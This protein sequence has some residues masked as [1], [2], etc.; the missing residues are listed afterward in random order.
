M[1]T[2]WGVKNF[3]EKKSV[4]NLSLLSYREEIANESQNEWYEEILNG[5]IP[6][7]IRCARF[8][9]HSILSASSSA[10]VVCQTAAAHSITGRI[11]AR[12]SA[13]AK[14]IARSSCFVGVLY[15]NMLMANQPLFSEANVNLRSR[16][17]VYMSSSVRLSSVCRLKR[18]CTQLR[19]LKFSAMFLRH[20]VP[21][22]SVDVHPSGEL[23]NKR[24]SRI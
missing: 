21:W 4:D 8:W 2:S 14:S 7:I 10:R 12:S 15:D 18:S 20:L 19:R 11:T 1:E 9:I 24:G 22:P 23:N 5:F 17:Q 6:K 3:V 16:S 13:H